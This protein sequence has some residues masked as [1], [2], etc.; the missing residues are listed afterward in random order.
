MMVETDDH[1]FPS[2]T[3]RRTRGKLP[4]AF[5]PE[6]FVTA[7]NASASSTAPRP[8]WVTSAESAKAAGKK[9]LGF[10]RA[11]ASVGCRP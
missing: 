8:W 2:T 10:V 11:Y 3:N 9:P 1:L 7:G 6:S 5:R 4:P